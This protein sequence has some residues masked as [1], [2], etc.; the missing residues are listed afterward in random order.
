MKR[1]GSA[2]IV[3]TIFLLPGWT[4]VRAESTPDF[5]GWLAELR[6]EALAEGIS[7][8]TFDRAMAGVKEP[9]P[10]VIASDR[11]QPEFKLNLESYLGRL[12]SEGRIQK[13]RLQFETHRRLL[14]EIAARYRV[15]PRFLLALWGIESDYGR[16]LGSR[17]IIPALV[18]LAYDPRRG[19][20]FRRELMQGLHILEEG[21]APLESFQG[22]WAG[23]LGGLQFMPS[24]YRRYAVDYNGDG[25]V[26]IWGDPGDLLATGAAYLAASGWQYDQT[27][28]REVRLTGKIAPEMLGN[29]KRL[30]LSRWQE[31]GVRRLDG[32]DLPRREMSASLIC[33]DPEA[34]R[35]FLIYDNFR[36]ILKWNRSNLFALA[37]GTLA[38]RLGEE[39]K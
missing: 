16:V 3:C 31:L 37:V 18:T 30:P 11:N 25:R 1:F 21:L 24:V 28:G 4:S 38:D 29:D 27:W 10:E 12:V 13:G 33:P 6:V 8:A 34:G 23:A 7:P 15:Q 26:D 5:A 2:I 36:V 22:S 32:R 17:P 9:E 20:Y 14:E 35:Y 39:Q 19:S